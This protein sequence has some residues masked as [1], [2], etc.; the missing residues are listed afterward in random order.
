MTLWSGRFSSK[1]DE[2]AWDLNTSLP[3]DQRLAIQDVNGSIAWASALHMANILSDEEHASISRGLDSVK[4]EFSS[5]QFSFAESDE[6]IHTAVE[7]RLGEIIGAAAGK[8]HTGRSRNDQVA[9]D[10]RL[11]MLDNLPLLDDA[12]KGF[13]SAL[14]KSQKRI[15]PRLCP[16][17]HTCNA[18]NP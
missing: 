3:F 7:R 15:S 18:H 9:T 6:D 1:L 8:L 11:W 10:F 2:Q 17:I 12:I 4:E 14:L 16:D 13:Q 5:G